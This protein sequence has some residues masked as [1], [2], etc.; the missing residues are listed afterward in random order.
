Y[1]PGTDSCVLQALRWHQ[2]LLPTIIFLQDGILAFA[3][4]A[5]EFCVV[6]AVMN[7]FPNSL[8][9]QFPVSGELF[10]TPGFVAKH[11]T[12][13]P[14]RA[15]LPFVLHK[16]TFVGGPVVRQQVLVFMRFAHRDPP[17]RVLLSCYSTCDPLPN[18]RLTTTLPPHHSVRSHRSTP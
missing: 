10:R 11:M 17:S 15:Q 4:L 7:D 1:H 13:K 5:Q 3:L 18:S 14:I 6:L 8:D 9:R 16:Q 2:W 12:V